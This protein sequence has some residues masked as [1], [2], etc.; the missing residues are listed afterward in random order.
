M[1][2][3]TNAMVHL[4]AMARRA[5]V[6][7]DLEGLR[8]FRRARAGHR[9]PAPL[10][11]LA[12]GGLSL[13][14]RHARASFAA[15]VDAPSRRA[16]VAGETMEED[17]RC[18]GLQRRRHP[19]ART[20]RLRLGRHRDPLWQSC[21]RRLRDQTAGRR[22]ALAE[23]SGPAIVFDA[24]THVEGGERSGAR[25]HARPRHGAAQC[26][27]VGGPGM[28]EWGMLPIPKKLLNQ[29]V[30]DMV[31][32]SDAR[33]SGTS[34]GACI[35]HVAPEA[36][37]ARSRRLD[38]RHDQGR[39]ARSPSMSPAR[40]DRRAAG[41]LRPQPRDYPRGYDVVA[42]MCGRPMKAAISISSKA[43]RDPGTG[44]SLS[45]VAK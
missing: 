5:G 9:Q 41:S 26:R 37:K 7:I 6:P 32:I 25:C 10:G 19:P 24:T 45:A 21:A 13:C 14:G 29:G 23:H 15:Q 43:A 17:R 39:C 18:A 22:S 44:N 36:L 1:A 8:R 28:P 38:R 30:R 42:S 4:V 2:G 12:D 31:R 20:I 27:P 34:Y 33:M 3:S 40:G 11:R 16:T 35:L